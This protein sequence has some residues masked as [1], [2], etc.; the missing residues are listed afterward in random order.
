MP[1]ATCH[2][3]WLPRFVGGW[4]PLPQPKHEVMTMRQPHH[5]Q[6]DPLDP[7]RRLPTAPA[8]PGKYLSLTSFRRD[9]TGVATP[10]W[11]VEDGGRLLVETDAASYKVRRIRR[12]PRVTI[13]PCT[14]TGRLRGDPVP[15]WAELLPDAEV[16]RVDR[17]MAGK[18]RVDLLFIKPFRALQRALRRRPPETPVILELTPS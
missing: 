15:A 7:P 12:D 1:W 14:A 17:L 11:F 4:S 8:L 6:L 16:A 5:Q 3:D 2:L 13:A 9:G 10:V 18:Y